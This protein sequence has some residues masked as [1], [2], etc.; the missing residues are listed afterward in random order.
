[1][2]SQEQRVA[3]AK[4]HERR[5]RLARVQE[6]RRLTS[7][8]DHPQK[9]SPTSRRLSDRGGE[10]PRRENLAF[11]AVRS[12][13]GEVHHGTGRPLRAS[14]LMQAFLNDEA[15]LQAESLPFLLPH[16]KKIDDL[17][18]SPHRASVFRLWV[19]MAILLMRKV[20]PE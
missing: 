8:P 4:T 9:A 12:G 16:A 20:V 2:P 6:S 10:I 3:S 11:A 14:D 5:S 15:R 1:M 17:T 19:C 13:G 18:K 7:L